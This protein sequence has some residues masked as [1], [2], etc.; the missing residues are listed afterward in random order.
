MLHRSLARLVSGRPRLFVLGVVVVAALLTPS[1]AIGW[2]GDHFDDGVSGQAVYESMAIH[3]EAVHRGDIT[4]VAYQ[5]VNLDPYI[6]TYN[7]VTDTWDGPVKVGENQL[8][9]PDQWNPDDSHGAPS[10]LIDDSGYIHVLYGAHG[11]KIQH[12]RSTSP[13]NINSWTTLSTIGSSASYPQMLHKGATDPKHQL[14]Y[15][16]DGSS[17]WYRGGWVRS[18]STR[19]W[20]VELQGDRRCRRPRHVVLVRELLQR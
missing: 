15:R 11:T 17:A 18:E 3:A 20:R 13:W 4:Y 14:F 16:V 10:L 9:E 7:H 5:G 6:V 1:A 8:A 19:R 2:Y 12:A